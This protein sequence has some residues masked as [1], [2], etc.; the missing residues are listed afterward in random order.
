MDGENKGNPI[1]ID[2]L[3][4]SLFLEAPI[5]F[6]YV[7]GSFVVAF[8]E[9]PLDF[10]GLAFLT[11]MVAQWYRDMLLENCPNC[12][13]MESVMIKISRSVEPKTCN[14]PMIPVKGK[15]CESF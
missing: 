1:K 8:P 9:T 14:P 15:F 7:F 2:D 3:G 6:G 13:E 12:S 11:A 10:T 4:V 5:C